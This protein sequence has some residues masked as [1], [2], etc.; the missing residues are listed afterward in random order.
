MESV[1]IFHDVDFMKGW[2]GCRDSV[3]SFVRLCRKHDILIEY[4]V[5]V[6]RKGNGNG[7]GSGKGMGMGKGEGG[8]KSG[9]AGGS[10]CGL[11]LGAGRW[12]CGV[13]SFQK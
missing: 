8:R 2:L 9:W 13:V 7:T 3:F 1:Y 5:D 11:G 6:A 10:G 12:G 4:L